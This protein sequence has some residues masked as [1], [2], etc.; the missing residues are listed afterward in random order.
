M[1]NSGGE[2]PDLIVA[3][4]GG[5]LVAALRAAELGLSVLVV[6]ASEHFVRGNN[7]AMSTAMI[8]GA[9]TR[10]QAAAGIDDSPGRYVEDIKRKTKGTA[11][12]VLAEALAQVS[13]RLV[14]WL[15]DYAHLP[16]ELVTDF[17][18]P[19]HSRPRCH[20]VPGRS[21]RK[22]LAALADS[23][24]AQRR[25]D[26]LVPAR[27]IDVHV[28]GE[29]VDHVVIQYPDARTEAVPAR[30]VLLA[31][32]GFGADP[33]LVAKY[34]PE[35]AGATYHGSSESR[36]DALRIGIRL[37][38]DTG[39][40][41]AYQGHAALARPVGTL[42]GWATVMHGGFLVN[43]EGERFG[44]ETVGYSEYAREVLS[45][46]GG[47]ALIVL[48]RRVHDAC[49]A[50]QDFRD[51]VESGALRWGEDP[52]E[53]ARSLGIEPHRFARTIDHAAAVARGQAADPFGRT[54]WGQPLQ[55]PYAAVQVFPALFHTQGGLRVDACG[56]VL[57]PD[58]S[59]IGGVYASGGAAMSISGHGPTGYLAGNGLLPAL[60]L[61]LLAADHC[62]QAPDGHISA[63]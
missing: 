6:E 34:I 62:A 30:A 9:G 53:L 43:A 20:T 16:L 3:G 42:A 32:N 38:A 27:L 25:I 31:T 23:V 10:W 5:G 50:F 29:S 51:T 48:D 56:R 35:M 44:D 60:G 58:G 7:T 24:R 12:E 1:A 26:L 14:T 11:D 52:S 59:V 22:L 13:G 54:S 4:A 47:W 33:D 28:D 21:G 46:P 2:A 39:Y 49:L 18:Y 36:G 40:L 17:D 19:G 41:D 63:R 8:P 15:A 45:Q 61:A 57:R 55:P 37:G